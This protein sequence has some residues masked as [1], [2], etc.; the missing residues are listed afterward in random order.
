MDHESQIARHLA[1]RAAMVA[2]AVVLLVGLLRGLDGALSAAIGLVIV[3]ANFLVAARIIGWAA[4]RSVGAIYGAIFGGFFVRLAVLLGIV[5]LLEPVSFIDVPVLVLTVA[6]SHLALLV[7]ETRSVS[8]TL[9]APGLKPGIGE[10]S[11]DKE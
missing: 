1:R 3:A 5:L 11:K 2:P 4:Q 10:A 7:W 6:V 8:L 9:A